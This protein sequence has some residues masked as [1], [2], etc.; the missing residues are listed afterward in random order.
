MMEQIFLPQRSARS[1]GRGK[2]LVGQGVA[3]VRRLSLGR[4]TDREMKREP[5]DYLD[6]WLF[7]YHSYSHQQSTHTYVH[8]LNHQHTHVHAQTP[9]YSSI[10]FVLLRCENANSV[11]R[12]LLS[13]FKSSHTHIHIPTYSW[14]KLLKVTGIAHSRTHKS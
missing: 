9:T 1:K 12:R 2:G 14:F 4:C 3:A 5:L 7:E 10:C 6:G 11:C 13:Y 8:V